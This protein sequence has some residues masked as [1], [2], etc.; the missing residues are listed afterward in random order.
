MLQFWEERKD[1]TLITRWVR[2]GWPYIWC[3]HVC[4]Q[5]GVLINWGAHKR[6]EIMNYVIMW[7]HA[8]QDGWWCS[9]WG[10]PHH[11]SF[12]QRI[13]KKEEEE[14]V[15]NRGGW[16]SVVPVGLTAWLSIRSRR[17]SKETC[18]VPIFGLNFGP[19]L[20]LLWKTDTGIIFS[21][22]FSRSP[23]SLVIILNKTESWLSTLLHFIESF[24]PTMMIVTY[25]EKSVV[26]NN[27]QSV[28]RDVASRRFGR[29]LM[30]RGATYREPVSQSRCWLRPT[31]AKTFPRAVSGKPRTRTTHDKPVLF[32]IS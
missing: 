11:L 19:G 13:N 5:V 25:V 7:T 9:T 20:L 27:N 15:N 23:S 6:K 2:V 12:C 30:W 10:N 31:L 1:V 29:R 17:R 28:S 3:T 4:N 32:G 26:F 8:W 24:S 22:L 18:A 21:Q 16:A 14:E